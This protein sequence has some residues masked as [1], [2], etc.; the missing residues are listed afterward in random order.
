MNDKKKEA[1]TAPASAPQTPPGIPPGIPPEFLSRMQPPGQQSVQQPL[2]H[3]AHAS[4]TEYLKA[5]WEYVK[6]ALPMAVGEVLGIN[7][8]DVQRNLSTVFTNQYWEMR[9]SALE[10]AVQDSLHRAAMFEGALIEVV[11]DKDERS[12]VLERAAK[13]APTKFDKVPE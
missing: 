1:A 3:P 2:P 9:C 5:R 6:N 7:H 4:L 11:P 12:E 13:N 10:S 8:P